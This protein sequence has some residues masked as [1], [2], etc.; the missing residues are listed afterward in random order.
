MQRREIR[1]RLDNGRQNTRTQQSE[2]SVS[3]GTDANGSN[4]AEQFP[5]VL[6]SSS[7]PADSPHETGKRQ[8]AQKGNRRHSA[9]DEAERV[10]DAVSDVAAHLYAMRKMCV[11]EREE[12]RRW[13]KLLKVFS[14]ATTE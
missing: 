6:E 2:I 12:N 10:Q 1:C 13:Q 3:S 14:S 5:S 9:A 8:L 11:P 4:A 7:R